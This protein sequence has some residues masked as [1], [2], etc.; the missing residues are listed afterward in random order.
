[1][2]KP[3]RVTPGKPGSGYS[4]IVRAAAARAH[5]RPRH[6]D[7]GARRVELPN[8]AEH[9]DERAPPEGGDQRGPASC[10]DDCHWVDVPGYRAVLDGQ[11]ECLTCGSACAGAAQD[12]K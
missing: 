9:G 8:P 12:E 1:M 10:P 3:D 2:T 11:R 6:R 5:P 4:Q 7:Q